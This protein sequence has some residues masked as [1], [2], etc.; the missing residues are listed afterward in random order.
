[1]KLA[2]ILIALTTLALLPTG[3][4]YAKE[5]LIGD[6]GFES[7]TIAPPDPVGQPVTYG[8][9]IADQPGAGP[10]VAAAVTSPVFAGAYAG[11]VDTRTSE[12]G[13]FIYQDIE[14][15]TSC[16]VWTFQ[17]YREEGKNTAELL[18][19]WDRGMG[20]ARFVTALTFSD[21]GTAFSGWGLSLNAA[22]LTKEVWHE[23]SVEA[24]GPALNQTLLIDGA[25]AGVIAPTVADTVPQTIILGDVSGVADNGLY[26]YDDVSL[27]GRECDSRASPAA[28]TRSASASALPRLRGDERGANFPWWIVAVVLIAGGLIFFFVWRRRRSSNQES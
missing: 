14:R 10:S 16:F 27:I 21:S 28:A 22:A 11:Q 23:I 18:Q 1:M 8:S 2:A 25:V 7:G 19:D 9:W 12:G 17:L 15:G 20:Q 3:R 13:R 26:T 5:E 4:G 24:D 6:G